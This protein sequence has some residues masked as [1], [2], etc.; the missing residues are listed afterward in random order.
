MYHIKT[1]FHE[2]IEI[3]KG[4][5]DSS[6][7]LGPSNDMEVSGKTEQAVFC[8]T[9]KMGPTRT[10]Q[11]GVKNVPPA[12]DSVRESCDQQNESSKNLSMETRA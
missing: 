10:Y 8:P 12:R 4:K 3:L 2:D 6:E 9:S 1:Y 11:I 7:H 5:N